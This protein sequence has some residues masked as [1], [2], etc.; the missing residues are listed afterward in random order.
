MKQVSVGV[1][2]ILIKPIPIRLYAILLLHT[3]HKH[4]WIL[5]ELC[6]SQSFLLP[7]TPD[8]YIATYGA[9]GLV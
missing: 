6:L 3:V 2:S 8:C 5:S 4:T 9:H 1:A 7:N